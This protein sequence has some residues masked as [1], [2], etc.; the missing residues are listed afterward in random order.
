M[1]GDL[2]S[3]CN[4]IG[5]GEGAL[6]GVKSIAPWPRI[7]AMHWDG[8]VMHAPPRHIFLDVV[9]LEKRRSFLHRRGYRALVW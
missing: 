4:K 5:L 2:P 8:R 9:N 1:I 6:S 3:V 7:S